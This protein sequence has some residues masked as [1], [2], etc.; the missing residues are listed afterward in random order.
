AELGAA[1]PAELDARVRVLDR[2]GARPQADRA[3]GL[4]RALGERP[5]PSIEQGRVR[6]LSGREEQVARLVAEGLSNAEV[7]ARL[8]IS[9]RTVTTHLQNIYGR[10]GLGSRTALA[11][12]VIE[13]LPAD[14]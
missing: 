6:E 5:A 12:Y 8:F 2:L 14:T 9:P 10:L 13:R 1:E 4:L 11:R 7:A 3:R